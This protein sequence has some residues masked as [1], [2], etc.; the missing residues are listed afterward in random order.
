MV[1]SARAQPV[2]VVVAVAVVGVV[3]VVVAQMNDVTY[4]VLTRMLRPK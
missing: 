4:A 2:V 3:V 1:A